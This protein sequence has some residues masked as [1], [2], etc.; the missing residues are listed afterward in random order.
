MA[1]CAQTPPGRHSAATSHLLNDKYMAD[2]DQAW[3]HMQQMSLGAGGGGVP[4]LPG[5]GGWPRGASGAGA[6]A[7]GPSLYE[8][9]RNVYAQLE[10]PSPSTGGYGGYG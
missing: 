5:P 7:G 3:E 10:A 4:A 2:F 9:Q 8:Q 6:G 1:R